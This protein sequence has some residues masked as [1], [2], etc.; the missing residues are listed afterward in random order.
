VGALPT[1]GSLGLSLGP[2]ILTLTVSRMRES[3]S[4]AGRLE[5][6]V[7]GFVE[8]PR[9]CPALGGF[10]GGRAVQP[11]VQGRKGLQ[12]GR[13]GG[14]HV[15]LGDVQGVQVL[16]VPKHCAGKAWL[17]QDHVLIDVA[18]CCSCDRGSLSG[19]PDKGSRG[20]LMAFSRRACS[21]SSS[22][23]AGGA[24]PLELPGPEGLE[25]RLPSGLEMGRK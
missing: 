1:V 8:V 20:M 5:S 23:A 10:R 4:K 12:G 2:G 18:N 14:Y 19:C 24:D 11:G 16:E 21:P 6:E 7:L 22:S 3:S 9:C 25:R 15:L 13:H 17:A